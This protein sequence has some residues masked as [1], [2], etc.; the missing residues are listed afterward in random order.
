M[1]EFNF[2]GEK[3]CLQ[4][5]TILASNAVPALLYA[6]LALFMLATLKWLLIQILALIAVFVFPNVR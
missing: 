3:I 6:L 4:L 5:L 2:L 1:I